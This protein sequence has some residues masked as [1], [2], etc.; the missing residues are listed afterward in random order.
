MGSEVVDVLSCKR[1]AEELRLHL[2]D[3]GR[4]LFVEKGESGIVVRADSINHCY[5]ARDFSTVKKLLEMIDRDGWDT[6][7][8]TARIDHVL[9]P[10]LTDMT[11]LGFFQDNAG[12]YSL[13]RL[14]F[15]M[16]ESENLSKGLSVVRSVEEALGASVEVNLHVR[17]AHSVTAAYREFDQYRQD[18]S[19]KEA[20]T[21][22]VIVVPPDD[23]EELDDGVAD[24]LD[25]E[26]IWLVL[27][28]AV[29]NAQDL[30]DNLPRWLLKLESMGFL[31]PLQIRMLPERV[32]AGEVSS[33]TE[34]LSRILVSNPNR[35]VDLV[36]ERPK[37]FLSPG[38]VSDFYS[39]LTTITLAWYS[40]N[41]D[42]TQLNCFQR[43]FD[44]VL[45]NRFFGN[46]LVLSA[47]GEHVNVGIATGQQQFATVEPRKKDIVRFSK[48][49]RRF[50]TDDMSRSPCK[51]C[52]LRFLCPKALSLPFLYYRR[53]GDATLRN[54]VFDGECA[55]HK[56]M[57]QLVL[58]DLFRVCE[59][60]IE[61]AIPLMLAK[62]SEEQLSCVPICDPGR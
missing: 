53:Q 3:A 37:T 58:S 32:L 34:K 14:A 28:Y 17:S 50:L 13:Y 31:V 24:L 1:D 60:N 22:V 59:K 39:A 12:P 6:A 15:D 19:S 49:F 54:A 27:A 51:D 40:M 2:C 4:R 29:R 8:T 45:S 35:R 10:L 46:R 36:F 11:D 52:S 56:R 16:E 48:E 55:L 43:Y 38:H 5:Y 9:G 41:A 47:N 57:F 25:Q 30:P 7:S 23:C 42:I 62:D 33:I 21:R 20:P 61:S 26:K 18:G 44:N